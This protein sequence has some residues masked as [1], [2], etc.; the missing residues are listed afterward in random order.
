M[1]HFNM[2]LNMKVTTEEKAKLISALEII[3]SIKDRM[4]KEECEIIES[5][6]TGEIYNIEE[7]ETAFRV[8][9]GLSEAFNCSWDVV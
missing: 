3:N 1:A 8:I 9:D 4:K 2:T 6:T 7:I 5:H